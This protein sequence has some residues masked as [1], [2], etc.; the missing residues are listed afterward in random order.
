MICFGPQHLL[1]NC[2]F[3]F[4]CR[5]FSHAIQSYYDV[6][7]ISRD[8]SLK[9]IKT[10]YI[11][12]CKKVRSLEKL[13]HCCSMCFKWK[14]GYCWI[15]DILKTSTLLFIYLFWNYSMFQA[16]FIIDIWFLRWDS[17]KFL[18]IHIPHLSEWENSF[19]MLKSNMNNKLLKP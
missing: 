2:L 17:L 9:E 14:Q 16:I 4:I 1:Y 8:A 3:W 13:K 5:N 18:Y 11:T 19:V 15:F 10:A 12:L 7:G 6:L